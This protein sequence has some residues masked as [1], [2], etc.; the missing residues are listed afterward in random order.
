MVICAMCWALRLRELC[1][2]T[3]VGSAKGFGKS[4]ESRQREADCY[5]MKLKGWATEMLLN[6]EPRKMNQEWGSQAENRNWSLVASTFVVYLSMWQR[7]G[8]QYS[9]DITGSNTEEWLKFF[10]LLFFNWTWWNL[11]LLLRDRVDFWNSI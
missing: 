9:G 5:M 1:P 2:L 3:M 11:L 7:L 10:S 6:M 4:L 8:G